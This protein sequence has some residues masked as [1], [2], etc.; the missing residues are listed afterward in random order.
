MN[1][2]KIKQAMKKTPIFMICFLLLLVIS[3]C[4]M[5]FKEKNNI[6]SSNPNPPKVV[7]VGDY[8]IGD[9]SEW[10][11]YVENKHIPNKK[12]EDVTLKGHFLLIDPSSGESYPVSKGLM[13]AFYLNHINVKIADN[14]GNSIQLF[15]EVPQAG[16]SSCGETWQYYSVTTDAYEDITITVSNPHFYGNPNAINDMLSSFYLYYY[17]NFEMMIIEE[18]SLEKIT[19][20]ICYF[21]G[22]YCCFS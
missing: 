20:F 15:C 2:D 14:S 16:E 5:A 21:L 22:C 3:I 13:V 1:K 9:D 8:K 10:N 6:Q 18:D 12:G 19:K 17:L 11:K 7:F 4:F